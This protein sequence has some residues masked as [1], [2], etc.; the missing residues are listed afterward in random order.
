MSLQYKNTP[1]RPS[2]ALNHTVKDIR[3][4]HDM[5]QMRGYSE[6]KRRS[7]LYQHKSGLTQKSSKQN[8]LL[9][10]LV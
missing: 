3:H 6:Q 5:T 2:T 4:K 10:G 8:T 1:F 7:N 9:V